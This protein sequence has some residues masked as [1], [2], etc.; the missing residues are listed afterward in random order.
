[1]P[2]IFIY[3]K[4][5]D[6]G[7]AGQGDVHADE[8]QEAGGI[9]KGVRNRGLLSTRIGLGNGI[10]RLGEREGEDIE[11]GDGEDKRRLRQEAQGLRNPAEN[12]TLSTNQTNSER[13]T[14]IN[15]CRVRKMKMRS[16]LLEKIVKET[17]AKLEG[18]ICVESEQY[19]KL[20]KLY[21]LQVL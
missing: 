17:G 13:S 14:K 10:E 21:V 9:R 5:I 20:L 2:Y 3:K 1:M 12:V 6:D 18:E 16:E 8:T 11:G 15:A 19:K 7:E 4:E